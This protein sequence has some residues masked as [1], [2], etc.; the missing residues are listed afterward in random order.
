MLHNSFSRAAKENVFQSC[1]TMR[2]HD[3]EIGRNFL[4]K[5]TDFI[6]RRSAAQNVADSRREALLTCQCVKFF[7]YS[8]VWLRLI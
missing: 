8:L 6:K 1:A 2:W 7:D 3:D 4:G 5:S